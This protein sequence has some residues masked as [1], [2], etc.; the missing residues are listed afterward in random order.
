M[1]DPIRLRV[2]KAMQAVVR[3]MTTTAYHYPVTNPANVTLDP[4]FNLF[5]QAGL[6]LP[7]FIVEPEPEGARNFFPSMQVQDF[8]RGTVTARMDVADTVD[9]AAR[10]TVWENLAAD[11]EAAFAIDVTLGGLVYDVR[12]LTPQPFVGVGSGV[13]GLI[14]PWEARMHRTYGE[15]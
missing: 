7:S 1:A 9:P 8:M 14:Q 10:A 6:D 12:L 4:T 3:G 11:L 2:L 15:P 5:L 13:V